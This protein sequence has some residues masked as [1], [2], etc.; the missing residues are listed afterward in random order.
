MT[1]V[2]KDRRRPADRERDGELPAHTETGTGGAV[3]RDLLREPHVRHDRESEPDKRGRIVG[4]RAQGAEPALARA[5]AERRDE[6]GAEAAAAP[7][8]VD[9]ERTHL[10]HCA[11][12]RRQLRAAHHGAAGLDH[13][14]PPGVRRELLARARQQVPGLQVRIDEREDRVG[15]AGAAWP[16]AHIGHAG[17]HPG[18][19]HES[20]V[21]AR[22]FFPHTSPIA[23]SRSESPSCTSAAEMT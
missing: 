9:H 21:R 11:A 20:R 10:R 7:F 17:V 5:L 13:H 4:E 8:R 12:E 6:R 1:A 22:H 14:E 23:A 3:H 15:V 19:S 18:V 2:G 16:E